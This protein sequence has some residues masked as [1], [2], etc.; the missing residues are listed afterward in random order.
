[1]PWSEIGISLVKIALVLFLVLTLVA[2]LTLAER[3]I[4]A[5]IQD[6]LGPNRVGPFGLLQPLADGLKLIFKEDIIPERANKIL[7]VMAPAFS[8]ITA[9]IALAVIPIGG[10][11]STSLFG[12]LKEPTFIKFQIADINVGLLYVFAIGSLSVYGV[13]LG[14]WASNSKYSL[15]GGLRSAAQMI[16]YELPLGLSILGVVLIAGSL[17]LGDIV[18]AQAK[19]WF[20]FPQILGFLVFLVSSFAE[21][22]RLP[23]DLPEAEPEIVAGYH[24]EYS[25][26]KFAM[27]FM[28]EYT[29]MIVASSLIVSLFLGGWYLLPYFGWFGIDIVKYWFLPPLVFI[30]KVFL[31][32]FLFIWVRWTLPRFRYDQIMNL[33]WK[34]LFP[35]AVINIIVTSA[36]IVFI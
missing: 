11:F 10:G 22:N 30:G 23:F 21:T 18:Q 4:S 7:Y 16:S 26:M 6:R 20:V 9:I 33:G 32:L 27:F 31:I 2:Y 17:K 15:L 35:L 3:R 25:S 19:L 8:F 34:V 5:F 14:G 36:V 24:T 13:V 12:L 29:H 1:M 28:A